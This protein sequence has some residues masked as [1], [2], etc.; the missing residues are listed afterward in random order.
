MSQCGVNVGFKGVS[1]NC[2]NDTALLLSFHHIFEFL[3]FPSAY[4]KPLENHN[5]E[6]NH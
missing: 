1:Q 2:K 4:R 6:Q 3:H 5:V